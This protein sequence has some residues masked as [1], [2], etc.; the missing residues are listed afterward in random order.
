MITRKERERYERQIMLAD[1]GE[2]GQE[3]LKQA[4][5]LIVGVGGLGCPLALYLAAAGVGAITLVD[6]D[7]VEWS[8]LNRQILHWED[9]VGDDK[10]RSAAEKIRRLNSATDVRELGVSLSAEN[11]SEIVSRHDL[12]LDALD[13]LHVRQILNRAAVQARIPMI[14][15]GIHGMNG[16]TTWILPGRTPC[17]KCLFPERL[18]NE[19]FPVL[20]T[21]PGIV[22]MIQA[23]EAVKYLVG[24]GNLLAGRLLV[25]DG[26]AMTFSE[27]EV[28][29][30]PNCVVCGGIEP[31]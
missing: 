9:N 12:I 26:L 20:G 31:A 13:D 25:Y 2:A 17:L 6:Y 27:I 19:K 21:T 24:M 3:K 30:D 29:R 14:Y 8:N 1:F 5:V 7:Q 22:A 4:R 23:T 28:L 10:V 16:M 15:G 18:D 11:A